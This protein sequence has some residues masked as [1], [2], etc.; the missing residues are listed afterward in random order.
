MNWVWQARF[1]LIVVSQMYIVFMAEFYCNYFRK[2]SGCIFVLN[3]M[4][5]TLYYS[6]S[7]LGHRNVFQSVDSNVVHVSRCFY[8]KKSA[9]LS[10]VLPGECSLPPNAK[11]LRAYK[12]EPLF[13]VIRQLLTCISSNLC[14]ATFGKAQLSL[15]MVSLLGPRHNKRIC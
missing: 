3:T 10:K 6:F 4:K 9:S 11:A 2:L 5:L 8:V 7:F 13:F 15:T 1:F 12:D 14:L